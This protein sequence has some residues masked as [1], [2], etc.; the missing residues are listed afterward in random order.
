MTAQNLIRFPAPSAALD[1]IVAR[2]REA[3]IAAEREKA[4]AEARGA[5]RFPTYYT[6]DE[7]RGY[8][9]TLE[10]YGDA[11]DWQ[12]ADQMIHAINR[13]ERVERNRAAAILKPAPQHRWSDA[14]AGGVVFVLA[15]WALVASVMALGG[16]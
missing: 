11:M 13:R 5:M 1:R 9:S 16:W 6:D 8:C 15:T 3:N 2:D 7:L 12:R 4:L 10:T 14:I